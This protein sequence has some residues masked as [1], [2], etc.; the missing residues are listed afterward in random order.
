MI[1]PTAKLDSVKTEPATAHPLVVRRTM[2]AY[3]SA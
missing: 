3:T 1:V 2:A